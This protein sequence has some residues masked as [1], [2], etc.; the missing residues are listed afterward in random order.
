MDLE[1]KKNV[2]DIAEEALEK[3]TVYPWLANVIE[4]AVV[5][6]S[7]P[8]ITL[9]DLPGRIVASAGLILP[10]GDGSDTPRARLEGVG[11]IARQSR[12]GSEIVGSS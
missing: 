5:L 2:N 4:R 11:P 8:K 6:G 7:E 10:R 9:T 12:C 3:L 1:S